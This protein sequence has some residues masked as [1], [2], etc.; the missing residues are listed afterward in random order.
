MPDM[1][2]S[3]LLTCTI[4]TTEPKQRGASRIIHTGY[5]L[6]RRFDPPV[7]RELT[8]HVDDFHGA[9]RA[10]RPFRQVQEVI[11]I[12]LP[13]PDRAGA[14]TDEKHERQKDQS[15]RSTSRVRPGN[16]F[17]ILFGHPRSG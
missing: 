4:P 6:S 2:E 13:R 14:A 12:R 1:G 7:I 9:N 15:R 8:V 3:L 11:V 17:L 10:S 5:P 16:A